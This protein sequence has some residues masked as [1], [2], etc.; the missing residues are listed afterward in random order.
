MKT[1]KRKIKPRPIK[2][3]RTFAGT[4]ADAVDISGW[5]QDKETYLWFGLNGK[6]VGTLAGK[7]LYKLARL[8]VREFERK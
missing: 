3:I 4:L 5:F 8:I 2:P 7:E 1:K 6:C